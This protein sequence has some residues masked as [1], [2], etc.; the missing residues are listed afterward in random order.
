MGVDEACKSD[1]D[2]TDGVEG[3]LGHTGSGHVGATGRCS[4]RPASVEAGAATT[5]GAPPSAKPVA[6]RA[7][8]PSAWSETARGAPPSAWSETTRGPPTPRSILSMPAA[9]RADRLGPGFAVLPV[10]T[11]RRGSG[12]ARGPDGPGSTTA[13]LGGGPS[14]LIAVPRG[15]ASADMILPLIESSS[16]GALGL[17]SVPSR[18]T[19]R[20]ALGVLCRSAEAGCAGMIVESLEPADIGWAAAPSW[21]VRPTSRRASHTAFCDVPTQVVH[22]S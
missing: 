5:R 21:D 10:T 4:T 9:R 17:A 16:S 7:A 18:R 12:I 2:T 22:R 8:P 14:A 6:A 20:S 13:G 11:S 1:P 19:K 15:L 3:A